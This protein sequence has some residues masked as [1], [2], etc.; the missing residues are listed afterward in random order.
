MRNKSLLLERTDGQ[1][2]MLRRLFCVW[3]LWIL[4]NCSYFLHYWKALN[5]PNLLVFRYLSLLFFIPTSK[6]KACFLIKIVL[7]K[8]KK[9]YTTC[10]TDLFMFENCKHYLFK[11]TLC[12]FS[13]YIC[14]LVTLIQR[15]VHWVLLLWINKYS[16]WL[17]HF[18]VWNSFFF[19]TVFN[20]NYITI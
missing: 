18:I 15:R 4:Y 2:C 17:L 10:Y 13:D 19:Q 6:L 12:Y 11:V 3:I 1:E 20:D 5:K 14:I 7:I 9:E 16:V 8:Q